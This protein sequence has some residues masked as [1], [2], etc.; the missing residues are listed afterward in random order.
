MKPVVAVACMKRGT[1]EDARERDFSR[2][3]NPT[4]I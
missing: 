4:L 3:T 1:A 2:F